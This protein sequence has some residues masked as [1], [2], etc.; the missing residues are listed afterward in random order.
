MGG[1]AVFGCGVQDRRKKGCVQNIIMIPA[2]RFPDTQAV[3]PLTA[4]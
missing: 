1:G 2:R 3:S 4:R